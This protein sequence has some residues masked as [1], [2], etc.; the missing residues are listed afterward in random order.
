MMPSAWDIGYMQRNIELTIKF[1]H[2]ITLLL[3]K[4]GSIMFVELW[5]ISSCTSF[6][7]SWLHVSILTAHLQVFPLQ[8]EAGTRFYKAAIR[9]ATRKF[10]ED[11]WTSI[12]KRLWAFAKKW[13]HYYSRETL[14]RVGVKNHIFVRLT[15]QCP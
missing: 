6:L 10:E 5:W 2:K 3:Y 4:I 15:S 9:A 11:I 14:N 1:F 8:M 12:S 13:S 7:T